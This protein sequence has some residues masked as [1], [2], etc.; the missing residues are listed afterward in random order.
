[1]ADEAPDAPVE[2]GGDEEVY[3]EFVDDEDDGA[4]D[5]EENPCSRACRKR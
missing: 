2:E 3:D 5:D 1:M 4:E